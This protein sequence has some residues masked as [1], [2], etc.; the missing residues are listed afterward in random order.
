MTVDVAIIGAGVIG[1][2]IAYH[3]QKTGATCA[4]VDPEPV[5]RA[6]SATWGSAGG[7]R[8]QRRDPREWRLTVRAAQRWPSLADELGTDLGFISGGHLH[9]VDDP[10]DTEALDARIAAERRAGI[11]VERLGTA[12]LRMIAPGIGP[13]A[14]AAGYTAG[15]GQADPQLTGM[16]FR[17]AATERGAV[18]YRGRAR[19][20]LEH[21]GRVTGIETDDGSVRAGTVVIAAGSWTASLLSSW[22]IHLPLELRVA[23]MILTEAAEQALN[24]TITWEGRRLSLKQTPSGNYLIGGG[25]QGVSSPLRHSYRLD[26]S[27]VRGSLAAA[28]E[29]W[30][31]LEELGIASVWCGLESESPDGVPYLGSLAELGAPTGLHTAVGFS[32]HGFQIAPAVGEAM[33]ALV[34]GGDDGG[35][36]E[37]LEPARAL[38][39][40]DHTTGETSAAWR[41]AG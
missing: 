27:A 38:T 10:A 39:C 12:E 28:R 13:A 22:G 8:S 31:R 24:P 14:L 11:E 23:Q 26:P 34:T 5:P 33:A 36:L 30:P 40:P 32:G 29:A 25:W 17:R 4:L 7:V 21:G 3:I 6:P 15:D 41:N 9:V 37:G 20:V 35:V 16:A 19:Q 2:S 1:A 18:L